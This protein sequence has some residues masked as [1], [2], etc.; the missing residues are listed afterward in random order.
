MFDSKFLNR[1]AALLLLAGSATLI[2]TPM[3]LQIQS[4]L[5]EGEDG[6]DGKNGD[7]GDG[8]NGDGGDGKNG[9]GGDGK[10]GDGA[11]A[12]DTDTNDDNGADTNDTPDDGD[13]N[14]PV[15]TNCNKD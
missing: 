6:G 15:G 11:D 2:A 3:A 7:G 1:R 14:C 12:N 4:A 8:K 13:K 10:N 5:A 9:D